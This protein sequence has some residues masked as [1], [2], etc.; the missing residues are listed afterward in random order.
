MWAALLGHD[1]YMKDVTVRRNGKIFFVIGVKVAQDAEVQKE[2]STGRAVNRKA[3][4][5]VW[6]AV[7][8]CEGGG[9]CK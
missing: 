9:N 6:S 2:V 4:V 1:E 3:W 5:D 8:A 7:G